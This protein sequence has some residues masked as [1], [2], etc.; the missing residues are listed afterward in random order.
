[1]VEEWS[2]VRQIFYLPHILLHSEKM[3][4]TPISDGP[5]LPDFPDLM[6]DN[7]IL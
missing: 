4:S 3:L 5:G 6:N 2:F 1:M 7:N